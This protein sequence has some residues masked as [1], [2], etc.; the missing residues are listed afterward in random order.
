MTPTEVLAAARSLMDR[1]D[2]ASDGVW[3]R[4]SAL[5]TRQAVEMAL[6]EVW[7]SDPSGGAGGLAHCAMRT[8]LLCAP[9]YL[10]REVASR[11][12]WTWSALSHAC[13]HHSY[14]LAP[15]AG[16]LAGWIVVADQL[17]QRLSQQTTD[18]P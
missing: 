17:I 10:D 1:P 16:E 14:D 9:S 2:G 3:P 5:L 8:Q 7:G 6:D 11:V 4:A 12:S 15:T 18:R 13:H